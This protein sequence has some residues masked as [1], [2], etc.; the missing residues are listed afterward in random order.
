MTLNSIWL[1]GGGGQQES[2][3]PSEIQHLSKIILEKY[4]Y[5]S[6]TIQKRFCGSFIKH[7]HSHSHIPFSILAYTIETMY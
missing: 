2:S 7:I 6:N 5:R 4:Q 3:K 1:I